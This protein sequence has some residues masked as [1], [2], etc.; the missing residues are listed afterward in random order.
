MLREKLL[1]RLYVTNHI[2][3][4]YQKKHGYQMEAVCKGEASMATTDNNMRVISFKFFIRRLCF[5]KVYSG[6]VFG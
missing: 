2:V 3:K 5:C 4:H 1:K 6:V